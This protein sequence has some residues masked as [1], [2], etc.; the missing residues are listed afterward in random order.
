MTGRLRSA[1]ARVIDV[2]LDFLIG[3]DWRTAAGVLLALAITAGLSRA[4]VS[5]WWL[6]PVAVVLL[7]PLSVL[8]VARR[9]DRAA[10][11]TDLESSRD[12]ST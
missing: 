5:A 7:L 2:V 10:R 6:L 12:P 1:P 11:V 9:D 3:D 8:R 4:G